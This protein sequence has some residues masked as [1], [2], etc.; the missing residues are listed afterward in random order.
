M[1]LDYNNIDDRIIV[2]YLTNNILKIYKYNSY[3]LICH[4]VFVE[5][6]NIFV[7]NECKNSLVFL[8][9]ILKHIKQIFVIIN[10]SLIVIL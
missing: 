5:L 4:L 7:F 1:F 9:E 2:L 8:L 10:C 3:E 6:V